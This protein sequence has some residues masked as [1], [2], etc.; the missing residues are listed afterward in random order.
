MRRNSPSINLSKIKQELPDIG[1]HTGLPPEL[2]PV[3]EKELFR[4]IFI[5]QSSLEMFW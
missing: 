2:M 3:S 5:N 1:H 4:I